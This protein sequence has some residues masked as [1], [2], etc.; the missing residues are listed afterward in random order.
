[1]NICHEAVAA[2]TLDN[3]YPGWNSNHKLPGRKPNILPLHYLD[4]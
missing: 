1:M 4:Q 2:V 3:L